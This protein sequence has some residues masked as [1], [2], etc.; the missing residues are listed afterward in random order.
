MPRDKQLWVDKYMPRRFD[1]LLS[2]DKT[3]REVLCWLK[4]WDP[5][6][7]K[8]KIQ[9]RVLSSLYSTGGGSSTFTGGTGRNMFGQTSSTWGG[10]KPQGGG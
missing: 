2:N 8:K 9:R 10:D 3:N 6:V 5:I 7:F 1:E 4:S